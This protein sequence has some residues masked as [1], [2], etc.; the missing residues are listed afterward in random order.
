MDI[1]IYCLSSCCSC[2]IL[3]AFLQKIS[4]LRVALSCGFIDSSKFLR[5]LAASI[6]RVTQMIFFI[7]LF[8]ICRRCLA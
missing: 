6:L 1:N 7:P 4:L 8:S 2:K 3:V 5:K